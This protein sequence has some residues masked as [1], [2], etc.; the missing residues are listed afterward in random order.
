MQWNLELE[1]AQESLFIALGPDA[2]SLSTM[3]PLL[4]NLNASLVSFELEAG[5][6]RCESLRELD[7]DED[8]VQILRP[9][10]GR[11]NFDRLDAATLSLLE[12]VN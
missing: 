12:L 9:L 10:V 5:H 4:D 1:L 3:L 11:Y 8:G 2:Q 7:F 6:R